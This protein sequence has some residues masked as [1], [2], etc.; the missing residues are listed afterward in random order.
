[1]SEEAS[2]PSTATPPSE[3][4]SEDLSEERLRTSLDEHLGMIIK[5]AFQWN[6]LGGPQRRIA[7]NCEGRGN[8]EG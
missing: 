6:H 4:N 2:A 7:R 1:M 3:H 5:E 8:G